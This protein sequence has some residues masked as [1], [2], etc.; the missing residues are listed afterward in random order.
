MKKGKLEVTVTGSGNVGT[1]ENVEVR[2]NVAGTVGQVLVM[3]NLDVDVPIAGSLSSQPAGRGR[4]G[5]RAFRD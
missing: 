2:L 1:V 3:E 4:R 5:S